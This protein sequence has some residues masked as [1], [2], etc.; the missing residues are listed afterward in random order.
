MS[1]DEFDLDTS[2]PCI[3]VFSRS[4]GTVQ[5]YHAIDDAFDPV[6]SA[7]PVIADGAVFRMSNTRSGVTALGDLPPQGEQ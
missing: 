6:I 2:W 3:A 4:N 5:W 1:S 7:P